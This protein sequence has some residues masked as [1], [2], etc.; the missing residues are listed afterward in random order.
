MDRLKPGTRIRHV[1]GRVGE[2]SVYFLTRRSREFVLV[3]WDGVEKHP[4]NLD[5]VAVVAVSLLNPEPEATREDL[6]TRY[7]RALSRGRNI[8]PQEAFDVLDVRKRA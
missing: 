2:V 3:W 8:K 5:T 7:L 6:R 1:D 4:D